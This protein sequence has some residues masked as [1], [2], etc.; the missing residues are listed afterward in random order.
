MANSKNRK[1]R[2]GGGAVKQNTAL[3]P[4]EFRAKK[5]ADDLKKKERK[6]E[7]AADDGYGVVPRKAL[8]TNDMIALMAKNDYLIKTFRERMALPRYNISMENVVALLKKQQ[9]IRD[10]LNKQ[11][12]ALCAEM[13]MDYEAPKGYEIKTDKP[14]LLP[15]PKPQP[16][17]KVAALPKK[18]KAAKTEH[19]LEE[20]PI[21]GNPFIEEPA[22]ALA[23]VA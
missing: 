8:E 15:V 12:A 7:L 1:R 6:L 11:N 5:A 2:R 22:P 23:A 3:T 13:H 4:E 10:E 16:A 19:T 20:V 9:E 14:A 21:N 18:E 17:S